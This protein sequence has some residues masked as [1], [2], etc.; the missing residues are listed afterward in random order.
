[1]ELDKNFSLIQRRMTQQEKYEYR[2][3]KRKIWFLG[4]SM[5]GAYSKE[6]NDK[7]GKL[8]IELSEFETKITEKYEK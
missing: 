7:M 1:M 8:T 4:G 5:V 2:A 6:K 3:L